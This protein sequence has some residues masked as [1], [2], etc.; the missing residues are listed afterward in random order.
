MMGVV[1]PALA[2]K[3]RM[4]SPRRVDLALLAVAIVWG[5]SYLATKDVVEPH[6]VFGFL[7]I[8][9]GLAATVLAL[10][11]APRLRRLNRAEVF[12]G[13]VFG[14]VLSVVFTLETYGVTGTSAANAGFIISLTIVMTPLLDMCVR[15]ARLPGAFYLAAAVAVVGVGVLTGAAPLI[16]STHG[17][18]LIVL[19]ACV[20]AVH[21]T[22]I[23][24]LSGGRTLDSARLT[25]VQLCTGLAVFAAL[26]AL[27]GQHVG[28]VAVR[29]GG[30][31]W[32]VT[33]YL[34]VVCAVFAF[35]VQTWAVRRTSPTRVSLLL[36]TEPLWAATGAV[37]V[38]GDPITG[39]GAA[40][41]VLILLGT[42]WGGVLD[43]RR[44][45]PGD[46][47]GSRQSQWLRRKFR[48]RKPQTVAIN[49][50][51]AG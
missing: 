46:E 41:A 48:Y 51:T 37:L 32:L 43:A 50:S 1:R 47:R 42:T 30:R 15:R 35:V 39:S 13:M 33:A 19:A 25:L 12:L 29:M 38:A 36:G 28:D 17:D 27:T 18:G 31:G 11:T 5:S 40:G 3:H 10:I 49:V 16:A 4:N 20:R 23:A 9:F 34:A 21:V 7:V 6:T 2:R 44:M 8:R 14:A 24:R 26:S 45:R 22:A